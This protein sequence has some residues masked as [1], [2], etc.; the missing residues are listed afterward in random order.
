MLQSGDTLF[1]FTDGVTEAFSKNEE[2]F[3][4]ERLKKELSYHQQESTKDVVLSVLQKIRVFSAG[5][6]LID[7]IAILSLKYIRNQ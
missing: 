6:L 1:M 5:A 3:S 2:V 7:D 4:E